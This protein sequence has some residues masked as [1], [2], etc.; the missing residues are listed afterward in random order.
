MAH[1][2]CYGLQ[3]QEVKRITVLY[4]VVLIAAV[5]RGAH[6]H[7]YCSVCRWYSQ[8]TVKR[9]KNMS[10]AYHFDLSRSGLV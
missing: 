3:R 10:K 7:E 2:A 1:F 9:Q 8:Q 4:F 6:G 5:L